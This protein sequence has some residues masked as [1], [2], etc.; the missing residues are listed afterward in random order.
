MPHAPDPLSDVLSLLAARNL[1]SASLRMGGDWALRFPAEGLKFNAV[2][3]GGCFLVAEGAAPI[4]L[5][6][7][8]CF[9]LHHSAPYV[10]CSDPRLPATEASGLFLAQPDGTLRHEA[11]GGGEFHA[12]GGRIAFDE[13]DA[14]LLLDAMPPIVHVS[15]DTPEAPAMR[16]MLARLVEEWNAGRAGGALAADHLAQLLLVEA[17]RVWLR[18]EQLVPR[19]GAGWLQALGDPRVGAAIRLLHAEPARRWQLQELAAAAGMSRSNFALRFK[20][21]AG[22]A[23]LDYLL[24]W[25][26]RLGAKALRGGSDPVSAIAWALGYQSESAFSHAFK[27]I[28]GMSPQAY[29]RNA[30]A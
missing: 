2:V 17:M 30:A 22:L 11:G 9:L 3:E 28:N 26:M 12:I 1:L 7:G 13:A 25:R 19:A 8:D 10:L 24:R 15:A 27:R 23:P 29:R 14:A 6:A 16:W 5:R 20:Q 21:L 4:R 18:S